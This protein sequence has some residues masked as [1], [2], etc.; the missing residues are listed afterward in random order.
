MTSRPERPPSSLS[1]ASLYRVEAIVLRHRNLGEADRALTLFTREHG[2][3]RASVRGA[4][5][6]KSRMGGHVE[7]LMHAS[8]LLLRGRSL[9]IVTQAQS[10]SVFPHVRDDLLLTTRGL[11]MA[12]L[13]ERFSEE[14]EP[15][16]VLFSHVLKGFSRLDRG[17][18]PEL[19]LRAF[20]MKL[21]ELEGYRPVL[22]QCVIC[23]SP[24][25]DAERA[26]FGAGWGGVLCASCAS[27]EG[28]DRTG[29]R[30][31]SHEALVV[32]RSLQRRGYL[33]DPS[34]YPSVG[35]LAEEMEWLLRWH[36]QSVLERPLESAAFLDQLRGRGLQVD[37]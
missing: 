7:P 28:Q 10:I 18:P 15:N 37:R 1:H 4:R 11:H 5:K 35:P 27:V 17:E 6:T 21:L 19:I 32:L 31:I 23:G 2:K 29:S 24:I 30:P 16:G 20:E 12:E 14:H 34:N 9:D 25:D 26:S 36:L 22:D 13:V 3:L 33:V 8:L